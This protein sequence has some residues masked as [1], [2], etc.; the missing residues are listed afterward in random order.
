MEKN[1]KLKQISEKTAVR[2]II[3]GFVAYG[4]LFC[5]IFFI[6][7]LGITYLSNFVKKENFLIW[8]ILIGIISCI[9]IYFSSHLICKL[10]NIDLF[11]KCKVDKEKNHYISKKLNLFYLL[12]IVFFVIVII[13]SL[14]LKTTSL[15][16][17]INY[18]YNKYANDLSSEKN[19][20]ELANNYYYELLKEFN[21]N[22]KEI[23]LITVILELGV[24]Y[25]FISL[26]P[27]QKELL[28]IYN[29]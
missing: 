26:I 9:I 10:S 14:F 8:E 23:F 5:F 2:A 1:L 3:T 19:G 6:A 21:Q 11:N 28:D 16:N 20:E 24:V 17:E 18:S 22:E 7:G 4:I 27:Y 13:S 25:S 15:K 29:K 12:C